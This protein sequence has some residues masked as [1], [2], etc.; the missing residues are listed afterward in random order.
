M[1]LEERE[2]QIAFLC[3]VHNYLNFGVYFILRDFRAFCMSTNEINIG[4]NKLSQ[5]NF[6]NLSSQMKIINATKY[7][8]GNLAK[9]ASTITPE[10]KEK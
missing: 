4:G 8:Q 5:V 3:I 9:I 6:A 2:D 10:E 7:F 1:Q